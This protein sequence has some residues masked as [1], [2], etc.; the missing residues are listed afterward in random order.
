M[1]KLAQKL[2]LCL[3][4]I[5]LSKILNFFKSNYHRTQ[6][7]LTLSSKLTLWPQKIRRRKTTKDSKNFMHDELVKWEKRENKVKNY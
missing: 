5:K 1:K 4:F 6:T 7:S 3:N 2:D